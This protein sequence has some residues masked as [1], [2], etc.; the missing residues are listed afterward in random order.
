[1]PL[2]LTISVLSSY[3]VLNNVTKSS[4]KYNLDSLAQSAFITSYDIGFYT[5]GD[6]GSGYNLGV[7]DG[8]WTSLLK[9]APAAVNVSLF[10]LY[11]WEVRNPLMLLSGLESAI[12]FL[13]SLSTIFR[14]SYKESRAAFKDPVVIAFLVFSIAFSVAVGVSTYNFGSLSRYKI[15]L[16]PF[17]IT[18]LLIVKQSSNRVAS[19]RFPNMN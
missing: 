4:E 8:T 14:L 13:L 5:G 17:Y 6:S 3:Y 16:L 11:L 9:L 12:I 18:A 10:R 19:D 2:V 7:Q 15:P 1:M